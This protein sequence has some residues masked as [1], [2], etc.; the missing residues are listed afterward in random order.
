MVAVGLMKILIVDDDDGI[1]ETLG[2]ILDELGYEVTIARDG[3]E[4][5]RLVDEEHVD[6]A[7]IDVRM[8]GISGVDTFLRIKERYPEFHAF[9]MTAYATN[10]QLSTAT[11]KGILGVM[12]KPLDIDGLASTLSTFDA[13]RA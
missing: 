13:A 1:C 2:D 4:A 10:E 11:E 12:H 3:F 5:I 9:L 6:L 8:P 7:L